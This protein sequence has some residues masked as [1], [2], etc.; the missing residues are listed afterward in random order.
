MRLESRKYLH[1][2]QQ[3][4]G[5]IARFTAG[6]SLEN[7]SGD[8][9]LRAAV[10]RQFEIVG[11]ALA[12]LDRLDPATAGRISDCRRIVAFRN[13]LIHGYADVDDRLVWDIVQSKV[14]SLTTEVAAML[15]KD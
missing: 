11:E 15:G 3:A 14:T 4:A 9:M 7:Y 1:D 12:Q 8:P 10:E 6:K 5:L 2:V 13:I